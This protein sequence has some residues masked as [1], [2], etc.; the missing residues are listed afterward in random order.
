MSRS[1]RFLP[2]D[3]LVPIGS[4][5]NVLEVAIAANLPLPHSC[6]GMGS[7]TT[8]RV[9]VIDGQNSLPDRN[10]L[11]AE[12]A[13]TRGYAENERLACQLPAIPELTVQIPKPAL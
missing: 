2:M 3:S 1:I 11:E 5:Q 12:I 10:E 7:C 9:F 6:G 8:C 13:S 4:S